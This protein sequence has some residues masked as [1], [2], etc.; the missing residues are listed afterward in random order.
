LKNFYEI[1]KERLEK[2]IIEDKERL[3]KKVL[4]LQ[5]EYE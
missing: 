5:E 2:K 4:Y 1:E 3:D